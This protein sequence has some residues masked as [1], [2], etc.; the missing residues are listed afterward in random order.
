VLVD[1]PPRALE[2]ASRIAAEHS[3]FCD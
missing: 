2:Q 3:V 1:R